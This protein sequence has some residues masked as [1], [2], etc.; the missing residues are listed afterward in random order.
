M[1]DYGYQ[2]PD[3]DT[4]SS[5]AEGIAAIGAII[6]I[7]SLALSIVLIIAQWK[8]Y[9]K[10]GKPG[11]A[12]IIP[13][14][15]FIVLL[16][17]VELPIWYIALLII[18]FA[19]IY[20]MFKIYIELS[21]KFGKSTGF[22]VAT[23]FFSFICLPILAFSKKCVYNGNINNNQMNT[24]FQNQQSQNNNMIN[25]TQESL[26]NQNINTEIN[27]IQ[28]PVINPLD[29]NI[30]TTMPITETIGSVNPIHTPTQIQTPPVNTN[31]NFGQNNNLEKQQNMVAPEEN[32]VKYEQQPMT[33]QEQNI[34]PTT[35]N[36]VEN[37]APVVEQP[38]INVIPNMGITPQPEV[39]QPNVINDQN[40]INIQ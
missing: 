14:Y 20:A 31:V 4:V 1:Y 19:N 16:Q 7:I 25:E 26:F 10:A 2:T 27:Q 23:F 18:P 22:G 3:Y 35:Q 24:D 8:I 29:K 38:Q 39:Q 5:L 17:I 36:V 6:I 12:S 34:I 33:I 30:Q 15:N 28:Q 37:Q 13:I 21:H 40:N 9:K 11:W 32:I